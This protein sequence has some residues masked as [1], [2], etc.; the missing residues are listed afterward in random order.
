MTAC[1]F[2]YAPTDLMPTDPTSVR[3]IARVGATPRMRCAGDATHV[4]LLDT[5][6]HTWGLFEAEAVGRQGKGEFCLRHG[7]QVMEARNTMWRV[8]RE[9][10]LLRPPTPR[11]RVVC[12]V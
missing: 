9:A 7:G 1:Q 5:Q 6:R 11:V 10:R 12:R 3:V 4:V 8:A 2:Q